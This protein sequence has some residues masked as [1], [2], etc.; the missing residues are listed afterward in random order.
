MGLDILP[1]SAMCPAGRFLTVEINHLPDSLSPSLATVN[2]QEAIRRRAE[3]IYIRSGRIP[4]RDVEN[5][6][7]AEREIQMEVEKRNP[8]SAIV[9]KV[10]GVQYICEYLP[11]SSEGYT[12]GEFGV[13]AWVSVRVQGDKMYVKRPNGKELE[14]R[15]VQRIG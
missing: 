7:Q 9:V 1:S 11:E 10:N 13:G 12:P 2:L 5:W 6:T 14:T 3:E 4:G 15:I 8:H